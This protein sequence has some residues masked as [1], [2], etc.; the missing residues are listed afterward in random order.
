MTQSHQEI[1]V[2]N[3][4]LEIKN[5]NAPLLENLNNQFLCHIFKTA[6]STL[7]FINSVVF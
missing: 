1:S 7:I 4:Y 3:N 5:N 2:T 6:Y